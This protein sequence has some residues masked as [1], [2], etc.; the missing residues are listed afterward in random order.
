MIRLP[1]I[2]LVAV[3]IAAISEPS[4]AVR[5]WSEGFWP[6]LTEEDREIASKTAREDMNG[7]EPGTVLSWSNPDSGN[8]GTVRLVRN[9]TWQGHSCREVVHAFLPKNKN[10]Q[11][12]QMKL[13]RVEDG[14]WKWPEPPKRLR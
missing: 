3:A 12:W 4:L 11:E 14:S 6:E 10:A 13:C 2:G 8:T 5:L 7:K 1:L 9:Y